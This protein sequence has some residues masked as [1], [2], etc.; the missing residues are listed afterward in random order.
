MTTVSFDVPGLPQSQGSLRAFVRG[1]KALLTST[2]TKLRSWRADVRTIAA[3]HCPEPTRGAV[4][5]GLAFWFPRPA[6]HYG[7]GKRS[8]VLKANAPAFHAQAPDADKLVRAC[9]DALSGIAYRDDRQ[10]AI[11]SAKKHWTSQTPKTSFAIT[12]LDD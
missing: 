7:T 6:S 2:N 10:V 1:N 5:L 11:V 4:G 3:D 8:N 12:V 9:F